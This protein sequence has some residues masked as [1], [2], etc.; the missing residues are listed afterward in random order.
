MLKE[1]EE[2]IEIRSYFRKEDTAIVFSSW[3]NGLYYGNSWFKCIPKTIFMNSYHD[4]V[5]KILNHKDTSALI[6]VLKEDTDVIVGYSIYS[7]DKLHWVYV[8]PHWRKKGIAKSLIPK[9]V[10]SVT[11]LTKVG[12]AIMPKGW[13][14]NP[15][16]I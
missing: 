4:I 14:F 10:D 6:A 1:L 3:L 9:D 13:V 16:L 8:K 7:E 11:H 15:F 5:D 12:E 2:L